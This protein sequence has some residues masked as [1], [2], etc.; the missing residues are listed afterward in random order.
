MAALVDTT[1]L[2]DHLR[3]R[4]EAND[5]LRTELVAGEPLF[6]CV[7]TRIELLAG[8]R[9][10][11]RPRLDQLFDSLIW[12]DVTVAVAD[13]AGAFASRYTRSHRSID[14]IDYVIAATRDDLDVPLWTLNVR[15]FPMYP[16]LE[17]PYGVDRS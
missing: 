6:A 3:G 5:L 10:S 4:R 13:R 2:I 9:A 14:V 12:I 17:P 7:L 1:V 11:E 15:H 8:A 16:D